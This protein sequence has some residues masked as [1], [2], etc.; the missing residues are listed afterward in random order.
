MVWPIRPVWVVPLKLKSYSFVGWSSGC[1]GRAHTEQRLRSVRRGGSTMRFC[2]PKKTDLALCTLALALTATAAQAQT[3]TPE[4]KERCATR[5]SV[6]FLGKSPTAA[7]V[8]AADPQAGVDA[9]LTDAAFI[10]RFSRFINATF[11][12]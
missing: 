1:S 11:N 9:L 10:E 2:R 4:A 3:A 7:M 12:N 8:T 5:L 6:A